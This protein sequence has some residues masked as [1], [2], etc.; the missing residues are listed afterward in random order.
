MQGI[1]SLICF[2]LRSWVRFRVRAKVCFGVCCCFLWVTTVT[3]EA[4]SSVTTD[5]QATG[6]A[7]ATGQLRV[8][9]FIDAVPAAG[10]SIELPNKVHAITGIDGS[11]VLVVPPGQIPTN[12]VLP[13][14]LLPQAKATQEKITIPLGVIDVVDSE[15]TEVIVT[16]SPAG[17]VVTLDIETLPEET[18]IRLRKQRLAKKNSA[19]PKGSLQGRVVSGQQQTPVPAARVFVRGIAVET[20]TSVTGEFELTLPEGN[21]DI[22]VIH[23]KFTTANV[24]Q[25]SVTA[26]QTSELPITVEKA[27]PELEELVVTAPHV[28]GGVA[29]LV[30]ERRSSSSVDDIIGA[31]EM[32]RSG[33]SNAAGALKR[34]TGITVVGGQYIYVRGMGERYSATLLNGQSVPSPEPE[35]R[36]IPLDLF[37]TDVLQSVLIQKTPSPDTPAE[38]GGGI[39]QLRTKGFPEEFTLNASAS[40]GMVSNATFL[41]KQTYRGGGLDFLGFDDGTR[42][43]P[44]EIRDKSP[45]R[46]G[47]RFQDGFTPEELAALGRLLPVNYNTYDKKVAPNSGLS[48]SLGD[49]LTLN[50]KPSGYLLTLSYDRDFGFREEENKRFIAS[51]TA[52]GG[53]ELN[54]DFVIQDLQQTVSLSGIFVAGIQLSDTDE[55]KSTTLLLRV[56]DNQT[57][58]VSGRSDDLGRDIRR[59]RLRFVERQ[60]LAQ[61]LTGTHNLPFLGGGTLD[62]RYAVSKAKRAEPDRREYFYADDSADPDAPPA[63]FQISARPAGNQR[64]WSDLADTVHD[65]GLDYTLPITLNA[66]REN[67]K[68][69]DKQATAKV[70]ANMIFRSREYDTLRLTLRAPATLSNEDRRLD[71]DDIWS[72]DNINATNGWI[73][74]DTTQPT[75]AYTAEQQIQAGYAMGTFPIFNKLE[76]TAGARI[77]RSRQTVNTFSPFNVTAVPLKAEIDNT[78][79]LP[80]AFAKWQLTDNIVLRGGY[81]KT[82][83]RPDFRELSESQFRDVVTATRFVGNPELQRGTIDNFDARLE[84]YFSQDELVSVSTFYKSFANPIEQIDLGGVDRSVSWDNAQSATN[85]GVEFEFRRRLGFVSENLDPVFLSANIAV[86]NSSVSLGDDTSG[87]STS[88]ER[89]LQGQSPYV[90]NVQLGYDDPV[91]SG[92]TAALVYNVVGRRIRDV[93]RLGTPDIFEEPL[94]Q[95]DFVYSQRFGNGWRAKLSAKNL[96]DGEVTFS[97]GTKVAR[98][99]RRGRQFGASLAWSW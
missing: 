34:V 14:A 53:L 57:S 2:N 54:N 10:V 69:Q 28:E 71:P 29:S 67:N 89:A 65:V 92:V 49:S 25:V 31:E 3:A 7:E 4:Q 58:I 87:V 44:Q 51:D 38:F 45:L 55:I 33:D 60:L 30:A 74:E 95:L 62:W 8:L 83:S 80:S 6:A 96:L 99:F 85:V 12:L 5:L 93:G 22:V 37:S 48:F 41:S 97:Q 52:V 21:Y 81:G 15:E 79:V 78:D 72:L 18:A 75:D 70:G 63:D 40:A 24:S 20:T 36:V 50:N 84:Y 61:Q 47:N 17:V 9:V 13:S 43:L 46:E 64:V 16:L 35:R 90:V 39:V 91:E 77:E 42:K 11:A 88:K 66:G 76:V 27:T 32:S 98:R 19:L 73:L 56:S 23:P 68:K 1:T 26:N 82:V 59:S 86:I 94:H